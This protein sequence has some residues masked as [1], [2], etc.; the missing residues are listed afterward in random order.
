MTVI[1]MTALLAL[2]G[3]AVDGGRLLATRR[4][5]NAIASGAARAGAQGID[6]ADLQHGIT[7]LDH[8]AAES[9]ARAYLAAANATGSVDVTDNQVTVTVNRVSHPVLL[10]LIGMGDRVVT[11]TGSARIVRGL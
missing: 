4:E 9:R 6:T 8:V 7:R 5:A 3:L 2:A 1:L 10:T 11:G